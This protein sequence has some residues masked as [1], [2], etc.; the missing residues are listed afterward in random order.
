MGVS[1]LGDEA[2]RL[3]ETEDLERRAPV[4]GFLDEAL[5][6]E[7]VLFEFSLHLCEHEASPR[8]EERGD[9]AW[10][11]G[12]RAWCGFSWRRAEVGFPFFEDDRR[13]LLHELV[14]HLAP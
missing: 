8:R 12:V 10:R 3:L 1:F 4:D 14:C 5:G 11:E 9:D 13:D 2:P 7:L 6:L